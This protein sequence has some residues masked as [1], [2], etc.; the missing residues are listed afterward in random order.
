MA[1][2]ERWDQVYPRE[3]HLYTTKPHELLIEAAQMLPPGRA[4]DI[5]VG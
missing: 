3:P 4:L 1:E 5:G 2:A